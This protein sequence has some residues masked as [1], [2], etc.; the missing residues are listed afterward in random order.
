MSLYKKF[1][2]NEIVCLSGE[3]SDD[4][5]IIHTGKLM[6]FVNQGTKIT[7]IAYLGPG[8][9][10]GELSFFDK[11]PRSAHIMTIEDTTLIQI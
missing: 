2:P 4:L 5:F 3:H 6:I 11:L 1:S 7:P 10:V 8:E 9:Y